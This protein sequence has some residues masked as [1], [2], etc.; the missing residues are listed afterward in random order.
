MSRFLSSYYILN[1]LLLL[2]YP[3]SRLF[4]LRNLSRSITD[5]PFTGFNREAQ[6]FLLLAVVIFARLKRASTWDE[7]LSIVF[8]FSHYAFMFLFYLIS[9]KYAAYYALFGFIFWISLK[10]PR[11]SGKSKII[12]LKNEE[13]FTKFIAPETA[14]EESKK[15]HQNKQVKS[16]KNLSEVTSALVIFQ[17]SWC[18][19]CTFTYPLWA[20]FSNKFTTSKMKFAEIDVSKNEKLAKEHKVNMSGV[21]GQL[22]ALILFQDG[23]ELL[24]FPPLDVATGT[25][26]KVN[27]YKAKELIKYFDLDKRYVATRGS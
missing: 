8:T 17:T 19:N 7:Y 21:A 2:T 4:F 12:K 25:Y 11:Y 20:D 16:K 5:D 22:P 9:F 1:F 18:D 6:I 10:Q 23:E 26:G 14:S 3:L 15:N 27:K 24:R 13:E